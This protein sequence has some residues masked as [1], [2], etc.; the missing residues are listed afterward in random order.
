MT[1]AQIAPGAF[2]LS[3]Q[4]ESN[5]TYVSIINYRFLHVNQLR[6]GRFLLKLPYHQ[7]KFKCVV[8]VVC[9]SQS[10][11]SQILWSCAVS[12]AVKYGLRMAACQRKRS[13]APKLAGVMSDRQQRSKPDG[14]FLPYDLHSSPHDLIHG[15]ENQRES[16]Q[17]NRSLV[18]PSQRQDR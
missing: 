18:Q 10:I 3:V 11:S 16:R 13:Y 2:F 1:R 9:H 6:Y 14:G 4:A 12:P 7:S 17:V 5:P 8:G 15:G